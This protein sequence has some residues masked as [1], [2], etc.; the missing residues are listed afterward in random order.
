MQRGTGV[1]ELSLALREIRPGERV[2]VA[3]EVDRPVTGDELQ[4]I[5]DEL[6]SSGLE[7]HSVEFSRRPWPNT[8]KLKFQVPAPPEGYSI[9][10]MPVL[11]IGGG[12]LG[13]FAITQWGVDRIAEEISKQL[14]PITLIMVSGGILAAYALRPRRT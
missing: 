7:V 12:L 10:W 11:L 1:D 14:I 4:V 8:L 2:S 9:A 13:T 5:G 3:L 6:A